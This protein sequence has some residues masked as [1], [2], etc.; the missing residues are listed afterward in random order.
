MVIADDAVT[1]RRSEMREIYVILC[2]SSDSSFYQISLRYYY[3]L[4]QLARVS[5]YGRYFWLPELM[6]VAALLM[7]NLGNLLYD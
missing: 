7:E 3:T 6:I 5:K 1:E 2:E 4:S